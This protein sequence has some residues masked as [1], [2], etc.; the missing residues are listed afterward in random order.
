MKKTITLT[1]LLVFTIRIGC[2]NPDSTNMNLHLAKA[3]N[4]MFNLLLLNTGFKPSEYSKKDYHKIWFYDVAKKNIKNCHIDDFMAGVVQ[5]CNEF[6]FTPNDFMAVAYTESTFHETVKHKKSSAKGIMQ[7]TADKGVIPKSGVAQLPMIKEY[8]HEVERTR[9]VKLANWADLKFAIYYPVALECTDNCI[10]FTKSKHP[11]T[12]AMNIPM[13][14]NKDGIVTK[15]E[16]KM[17]T[18]K[19]L[20]PYI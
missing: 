20:K 7:M 17:L 16:V 11:N 3:N 14:V 12:Y 1:L 5:L 4:D 10:L 19:K 6:H 9:K 8:L 15:N 2:N 13:D 18:R